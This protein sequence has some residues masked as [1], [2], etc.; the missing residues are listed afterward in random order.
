[1][2]D[3]G[4]YKTVD[5]LPAA[6]AAVTIV[7]TQGEPYPINLAFHKNAFALVMVPLPMPSGV[8]G[9]RATDEGYSIRIVKDYDI[10][11]DDEVC[12]LDVLYGTKTLYPELGVRIRGAEG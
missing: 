10:D 2:I 5:T 8:W 4:P 6:G 1:M 7:G 9:A 11:K 3:T 12:R